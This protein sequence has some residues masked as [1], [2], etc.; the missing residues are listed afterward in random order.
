MT[1]PTGTISASQVNTELRQTS[2][3][4]IN[5]NNTDVRRLAEKSSGVVSMNDLRGKSLRPKVVIGKLIDGPQ[6][7][8]GFSTGP[9]MITSLGT[10]S[11]PIGSIDYNDTITHGD[12]TIGGI[13]GTLVAAPNNPYISLAIEFYGTGAGTDS[14]TTMHMQIPDGGTEYTLTRASAVTNGYIGNDADWNIVWQVQST[15]YDAIDANIGNTMTVWF[16]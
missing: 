5:L 4:S 10:N 13:G 2:T 1:L 9:N 14:F 11:G 16:T 12:W 7:A 6:T 8:V 15:I 3:A